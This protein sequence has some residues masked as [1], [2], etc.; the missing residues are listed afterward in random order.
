MSLELKSMFEDVTKNTA[1]G[2]TYES[3]ASALITQLNSLATNSKFNGITLFDGGAA[4]SADDY[5]LELYLE[6]MGNID[7]SAVLNRIRFETEI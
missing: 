3:E 7:S 6:D 5:L 4:G 2:D 1:D